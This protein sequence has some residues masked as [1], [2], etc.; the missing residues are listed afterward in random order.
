MRSISR[1]NGAFASNGHT[2]CRQRTSASGLAGV[3]EMAQQLPVGRLDGVQIDHREAVAVQLVDRGLDLWPGRVGVQRR[4]LRRARW[5]YS[6]TARQTIA[7][8]DS[9]GALKV[10]GARLRLTGGIGRE[11]GDVW[12]AIRPQ[13]VGA[14]RGHQIHG[15]MAEPP[16]PLA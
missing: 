10:S 13:N 15:A 3:D 5:E 6:V 11:Y 8:L 12:Y 7:W 9:V 1:R 4:A 14:H 16:R 2:A